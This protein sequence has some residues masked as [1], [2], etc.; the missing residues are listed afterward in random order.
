MKYKMPEMEN[1]KKDFKQFIKIA[2]EF[3]KKQ[4]KIRGKNG[5]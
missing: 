1:I 4:K 2:D 3:I 5:L